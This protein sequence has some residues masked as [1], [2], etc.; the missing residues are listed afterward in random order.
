MSS[1]CSNNENSNFNA[2]QTISSMKERKVYCPWKFTLT[3]LNHLLIEWNEI[4]RKKIFKII[5]K[6]F[7]NFLPWSKMNLLSCFSFC[8]VVQLLFLW[9]IKLSQR[10]ISLITEEASFFF[11]TCD[12]LSC[13][14]LKKNIK[15]SVATN[16]HKMSEFFLSIFSSLSSLQFIKK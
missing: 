14:L 3:S 12:E 5:P 1:S 7:F 16:F 9:V 6:T 8:Y 4:I 15:V 11:S 13:E 2:H 10:K